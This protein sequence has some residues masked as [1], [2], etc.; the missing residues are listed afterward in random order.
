VCKAR[1]A[2]AFS[3]S[4]GPPASGQF[5]R[6]IRVGKGALR[7][8]R[9]FVRAIEV[10]QRRRRFVRNVAIE[11]AELAQFSGRLPGGNFIQGTVKHFKLQ[12]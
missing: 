12:Q 9:P 2:S 8:I 3:T 1:S 4:D 11:R 10:R 6:I 5:F 7:F